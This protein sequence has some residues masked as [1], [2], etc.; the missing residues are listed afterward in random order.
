M[1]DHAS[2][3][4]LL[5][6]ARALQAERDFPALAALLAPIE[7]ETLRAEPELGLLLAEAWRRGGERDAALALVRELEP[8][9]R[10]RGNDRL[11]RGRANLEGI[12]LFE[13]GD[14]AGAEAQW[15]HLVDAAAEGGDDEFS[16]RA[17]QNL[18]II[19]TLTDRREQALASQERAI[20]AYQRL[21]HLRGLAQAHNNLAISYRE[22]GFWPEADQA[23]R[24][25]RGYARADG[26]E[27]ELGRI[28][29]ESSL[30]AAMRGDGELGAVT[31]ERALGR[32]RR[33]REPAGVAEALRVLGVVALW[34]GR[35]DEAAS[36]LGE[37][38]EAARRLHL[39]LLEA[40]T[41]EALAALAAQR[42]GEAEAAR[43]RAQAE[44]LFAELGA[45]QWGVRIRAQLNEHMNAER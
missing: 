29:L 45:V 3:A 24:Q 18:G 9:C 41:L 28:E 34:G 2:S 23:F 40:E 12:L 36:R 11:Y 27:D 26:S 4:T 39:R 31:A 19:Y 21:G 20:I 14:V 17:N 7:R 25:A 32:F 8:L 1:A 13:R 16:A 42:D 37:A 44:A 38:L 22:I 35:P 15:C 10:W 43:L 33:L 6:R 30:L 5:E